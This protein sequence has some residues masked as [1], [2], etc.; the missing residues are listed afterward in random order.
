MMS[1]QQPFAW[2]DSTLFLR[3][4]DD[5]FK[6][7]VLLFDV[8]EKYPAFIEQDPVLSA[9]DDHYPLPILPEGTVAFAGSRHFLFINEMKFRE[10]FSDIALSGDNRLCRCFVNRDGSVEPAALMC[11][12]LETRNLK[13]GMSM[14]VI[15]ATKEVTINKLIQKP[16]ASYLTGYVSDTQLKSGNWEDELLTNESLCV[17]IFRN[18]RA[19]LRLARL[20]A[21][22]V[23]ELMKIDNSGESQNLCLSPAILASCPSS[24]TAGVG[25]GADDEH[26]HEHESNEQQFERHER[27]ANAVASLIQSSP[28]AMQAILEESLGER[29]GSLDRLVSMASGRM[30]SEL[31]MVDSCKDQNQVEIEKV[32]RASFSNTDDYSDLHPPAAF[33]ELSLSQIQLDDGELLDDLVAPELLEGRSGGGRGGANPNQDP[34]DDPWGED[35]QLQ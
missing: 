8:P 34:E 25:S 13:S 11:K 24:E 5:A 15:Q 33:A 26:E 9:S 28:I 2:R 23:A 4:Q 20:H 3:N 16:N 21:S 7:K 29:L 17:E 22:M 14:Y 6:G 27:F 32:L 35:Y 31:L 18:L 19:Y 1:S 12:V 10:M 30:K